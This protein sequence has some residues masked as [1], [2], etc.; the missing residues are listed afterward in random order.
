MERIT[1][2]KGITLIALI[3]TIVVL[4]ILA[5]VSIRIAVGDD[6]ILGLTK[7][8]GKEYMRAQANESNLLD[9]AVDASKNMNNVF[10]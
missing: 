7:K 1:Q 4:L 10:Y 2:E 6:S 8:S 9:D 3:V 5:I